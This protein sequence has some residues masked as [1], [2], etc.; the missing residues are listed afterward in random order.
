MLL[1]V[2]SLAAFL[3]EPVSLEP[4]SSDQFAIARLETHQT[5]RS[6]LSETPDQDFLRAAP[7]RR[8]HSGDMTFLQ[9]CDLTDPAADVAALNAD[10]VKA[11]SDWHAYQTAVQAGRIGVVQVDLPTS[12]VSH[13]RR[14]GRETCRPNGKAG[15]VRARPARGTRRGGRPTPLVFYVRS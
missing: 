2:L 4:L 9:G 10:L 7:A 13:C 15:F 5:Q 14:S 8:G 3:Q 11:S 6:S 12:E 1:L